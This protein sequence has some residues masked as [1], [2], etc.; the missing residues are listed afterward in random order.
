MK[1]VLVSLFVLAALSA[2]ILAGVGIT[3]YMINTSNSDNVFELS[4]TANEVTE[5]EFDEVMLVPGDSVEYVVELRSDLSAGYDLLISF[6]QDAAEDQLLRDFAYLRMEAEGQI[7]CDRLLS[8]CI[9]DE[10]IPLSCYLEDKKPYDVTLTF[11]MPEEVGNDAK[12][13]KLDLDILF[14]AGEAEE[15]A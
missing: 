10:A 12:G 13:T 6:Y 4:L 15:D 7:L 5:L 2:T 14:A 9:R 3:G 8:D 1:N 11:Y